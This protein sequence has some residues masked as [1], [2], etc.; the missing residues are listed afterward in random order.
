MQ[1]NTQQFKK[2][3]KEYLEIALR[4]DVEGIAS[5]IEQSLKKSNIEPKDLYHSVLLPAQHKV[6]ELWEKGKIG[7]AEEH[8]VTQITL[9]QLT[10]LSS[11]VAPKTKINKRVAVTAVEGDPYLI[12][13]QIIADVFREDGWNV[14]YL[15]ANT[16]IEDLMEFVKERA[17]DV[18]AVSASLE[19]VLPRVK[20]LVQLLKK[21]ENPPIIILSGKA[22]VS[23]RDYFAGMS[24]DCIAED[25]RKA[26]EKAR[27]LCDIGFTPHT[28]EDVLFHFRKKV[29]TRRVELDMSQKDLAD[30]SGLDRA[31]IS[32]VER[33]KQNV[34]I[35][36]VI[37]L[38]NALELDFRDLFVVA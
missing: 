3:S 4:G 33:G 38:A 14:N 12:Q 10:Y 23:N 2:I 19:Y 32:G 5:L 31:Y 29:N 1:N 25:S 27:K 22:V 6:T 28:L 15:G 9:K 18:V 36:V 37:K 17:V 21:L 7:V 13:T 8:L 26:L 20:K 16:P 34:S 24:V 30:K 35:S 11:L